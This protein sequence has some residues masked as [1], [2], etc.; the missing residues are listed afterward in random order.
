MTVIATKND[1]QVLSGVLMDDLAGLVLDHNFAHRQTLT[2]ASATDVKIGDVVVY[3]S[4][5]DQWELAATGATLDGDS[6]LGFGLGVVVGFESLGD[7]YTQNMTSGN[8]VVLYQGAVNVKEAG[9]NFG[10]LNGTETAA[11]K[12]QLGKQGIKLMATTSGVE[13]SFYSASV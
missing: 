5:N 9:L 7:T 8:V 10:G 13:T 1:A 2:E 6:P 11:A 3:D 4:V 12:A